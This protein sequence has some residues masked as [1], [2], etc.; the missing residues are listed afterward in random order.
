MANRIRFVEVRNLVLNPAEAQLSVRLHPEHDHEGAEVRGR[1]SGPVC[2]YSS[3]VEVAYPLQSLV[4]RPD[5][6]GNLHKRVVIPDPSWW[7]PVSPFLYNTRIEL[8]ENGQLCDRVEMR[9]G[10]HALRRR[11]RH[12]SLNGRP[13]R[14]RAARYDHESR[15]ELLLVHQAD[16]NALVVPVAE[17][18]EETWDLADHLGFLVIGRVG[19]GEESLSLARKLA[20]HPS[21]FGWILAP[22]AFGEKADFSALGLS[23]AEGPGRFVG[24]QWPGAGAR[25]PEG[26]QF[27]LCNEEDVS[28]AAQLPL[29]ILALI[30]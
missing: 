13:L 10:L 24:V 26:A 17:N 6:P 8:W 16:V 29:P 19:D 5:D 4:G 22:D 21:V 11:G 9:H 2:A 18:C 20:E 14:I 25:Y 12:F 28:S 15:E 23:D 7:E 30:K 3:T 1:F 27:I